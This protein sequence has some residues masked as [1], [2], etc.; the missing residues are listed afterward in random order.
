MTSTDSILSPE[1][2]ARGG[3][4]ARASGGTLAPPRPTGRGVALASLAWT[5][6]ALLYALAIT[7][8]AG[9]PFEYAFAGQA[10]HAVLMGV[11]SVAPWWL[12]V[13][14]MAER[15]Q[16]QR[17]LAHVVGLVLYIGIVTGLLLAWASL[18][19]EASYRA[20]LKQ[21]GWIALSTG[22][23]YVTQFAVF[24]A[25]EASRRAKAREAQAVALG[26]LAREQELRTLRAQLNPHFLFN[27]LN[28][29]NAQI[30]RDPAAAQ[31]TVGRLADLL[32]Y[33]LD[34]DRRD[35]VPLAEEVAFVRA[36]LDLEQ[37][38]MG[39]RLATDLDVAPEALEVPV[40]PMAIQT[41]VENAVRHA[42]APNPAGG[43][44]RVEIAPEA[45]GDGALSGVRVRVS[46][47][48]AGVGVASPGTRTGLANT[49][50]RL[51]L[52]FG[53]SAA[54]HVDRDRPEGWAVGFTLPVDAMPPPEASAQSGAD[55]A[56][57]VAR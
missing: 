25:V 29:V 55:R 17:L 35:V 12:I 43:T 54:L 6:Y 8:F 3:A 16:R 57:R 45:S 11:L 34:A 19:G 26:H 2:S 37:S 32:R 46:D 31:E 52:L 13:R 15:P 50:E 44:V 28:T 21:S 40:P 7:A 42:L 18:G 9:V 5:L 22:F 38:R 33:A 36:Y 51:R 30:G 14:G 20:T 49:D 53:P 48:G 47:T 56:D 27:A 39:D 1:A 41:L 24:H 10:A 4:R 23:A